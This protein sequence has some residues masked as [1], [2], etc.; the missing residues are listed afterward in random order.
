MLAQL[1]P[2][3]LPG[4]RYGSFSGRAASGPDTRKTQLQP[5]AWGGRRYGSFAGR[6]PASFP[7]QFA[8]L[9]VFYGG[10]VHDLCLVAAADAPSGMGAVP[11]VDKNGTTYAAYLVDTTD[12]NAS[13]VRLETTTGTKAIRLKT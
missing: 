9:R 13:P 2:N 11:R 1:Q 7:T 6:A 5:G 10:A 3:A 8:G 12:P 4:R